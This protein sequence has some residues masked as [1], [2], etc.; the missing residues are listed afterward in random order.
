MN[1]HLKSMSHLQSFG[2][3]G[4]IAFL[5]VFLTWNNNSLSVFLYQQWFLK[6]ISMYSPSIVYLFFMLLS[7]KNEGC[8]INRIAYQELPCRLC[9][10]YCSWRIKYVFISRLHQHYLTHLCLWMVLI[11]APL[12]PTLRVSHVS[13]TSCLHLP[14]TRSLSRSALLY[15]RSRARFCSTSLTPV[16]SRLAPR[17]KRM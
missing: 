15:S 16:N 2:Y 1:C 3:S 10:Q 17:L 8:A 13:R 6:S 11:L 14:H 7:A 5:L 4:K 12:C 9:F